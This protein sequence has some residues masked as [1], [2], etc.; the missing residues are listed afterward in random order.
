MALF[1]HA[2]V[3]SR[4]TAVPRV[5]RPKRESP[6][7]AVARLA[8]ELT[9]LAAATETAFA[10]AARSDFRL[11]VSDRALLDDEHLSR[12]ALGQLDA[13]CQELAG[14]PDVPPQEFPAL[15]GKKDFDGMLAA[16]RA[17][18]QWLELLASYRFQTVA[19]P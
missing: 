10:E 11:D 4:G 15:P 1:H 13:A 17:R 9:A 8:A 12:L 5:A 7:Q 14:R 16:A 2:L 3:E 6:I 18:V 19:G